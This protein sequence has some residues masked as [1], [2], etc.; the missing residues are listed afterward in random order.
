MQLRAEQLAA[1]L[2]KPLGPPQSSLFVLH[3][4]EPLLKIGRASCRERVS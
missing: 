2:A 3:G 1:H 4:D